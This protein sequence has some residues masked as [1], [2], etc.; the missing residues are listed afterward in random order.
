MLTLWA[1][2]TRE[3]EL[4]ELISGQSL[5]TAVAVLIVTAF[6][7]YQFAVFSLVLSRVILV[8]SLLLACLFTRVTQNLFIE[9]KKGYHIIIISHNITTS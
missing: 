6:V 4:A 8:F 9:S 3:W 1:S 7:S 2:T 5:G